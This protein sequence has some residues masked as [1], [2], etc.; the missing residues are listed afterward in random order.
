MAS[1]QKYKTKEGI[2]WLYKY[3]G[4]L[5]PSTGKR[6]PSTKRGFNTKKEAQL[7]AAQ[8][9]K[10]II[11]GSFLLP[12]VNP[13]YGEVYKQWYK[14]YE[15]KVKAP[16]LKT[17]TSKFSNHVLPFFEKL[18]IKEITK[19]YCQDVINQ[20]AEKIKSANE[21]K[22][23]ADQIFKYA[24]SMEIIRDTP[25]KHVIVPTP[26]DEYIPDDD[27]TRNYW[28]KEEVKNFLT[29]AK[30]NLNFI[31]Y[32]LFHLLIYTGGRKGEVLALK[33]SDINVKN[34]T[35]RFNKTLYFEDDNFYLITPKTAAS[36][37]LIS[38]DDATVQMLKKWR[39]ENSTISDN[40]VELKDK[41]IF[42]RFDGLPYRLAYPND[43]LDS[44]IE[45]HDLYSITV[46]GLRHTHASI[47]FAAGATMKE[48]QVRLG[49]SD[50][51]MTMNIYTHVTKA[52]KE[53]TANKFKL[54]MEDDDDY[55]VK[56][57]QNMVTTKKI[58]K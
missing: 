31:D 51:K 33:W 29:I 26:K 54:F 58:A 57:G 45:N 35:I 24:V 13:T 34:Q 5:D 39:T 20:V 36:K 25:M 6:K 43:K 1:Y 16:T 14:I 19:S 56:N 8:T 44:I 17:A 46:H 41:F 53:Q 9:E 40:V 50:I 21:I 15:K 18:K 2:K 38:I 30:N 4:E 28:E 47:L 11:E 48:V 52:V 23:Y 10:E 37:R 7:H 12:S 32:L 22:M 27:D 3:Y 49:H 55:E 42:S